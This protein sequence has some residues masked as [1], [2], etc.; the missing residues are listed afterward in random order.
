LPS[1][2]ARTSV[3]NLQPPIPRARRLFAG[4]ILGKS[5]LPRHRCDLIE[6]HGTHLFPDPKGN[7]L[8]ARVIIYSYNQHIRPLPPEPMV[9]KQSQ[10]TRAKRADIVMRSSGDP[11]PHMSD[12]RVIQ[13]SR[14]NRR[15][16][17]RGRQKPLGGCRAPAAFARAAKLFGGVRRI[18]G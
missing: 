6:V 14:C 3:R 10:F 1:F 4:S 18:S 12:H 8:K 16:L 5:T 9:V 11:V 15:D 2:V 17:K 13:A 7:L